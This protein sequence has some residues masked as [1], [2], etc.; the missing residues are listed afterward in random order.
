MGQ[1]FGFD[2]V[3]RVEVVALGEGLEGEVWEDLGEPFGH[4]SVVVG[5]AA[6][7]ERE[8]DRSIE[9]AQRFEVEIRV[10]E[11]VDEGAETGRA[12]GHPWRRWTVGRRRWLDA[13]C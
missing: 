13:G 12:P 5:I 2:P 8:V 11:G 1:A 3:R 4:A 9:G 7:A 6:A 10:V